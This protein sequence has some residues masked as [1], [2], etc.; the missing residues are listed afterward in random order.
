[1]EIYIMAG[2]CVACLILMIISTSCNRQKYRKEITKY[3]PDSLFWVT[4]FFVN[5]CKNFLDKCPAAYKTQ[6]ICAQ[7]YD[8]N[9]RD[10]ANYCFMQYENCNTWRNW[11]VFKRERC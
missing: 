8:G 2:R 9:Y 3:P 1:M 7:D 11:R 10:F 6:H 4:D 5:G